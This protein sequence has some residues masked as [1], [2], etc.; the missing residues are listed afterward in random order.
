MFETASFPAAAQ[1]SKKHGAEKQLTLHTIIYSRLT[2]NLS[3]EFHGRRNSA[4]RG[5]TAAAPPQY[6]PK[7]VPWRRR[8]NDDG[9]V[10]N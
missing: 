7:S 10:L 9:P 5:K 6:R 8:T 2:A 3:R 4:L 1:S